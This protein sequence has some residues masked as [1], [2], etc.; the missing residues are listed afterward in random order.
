MQVVNMLY[1]PQNPERWGKAHS[2]S[3]A[4]GH[5]TIVRFKIYLFRYSFSGEQKL[6]L[7]AP[8]YTKSHK[9]G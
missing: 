9:Y 7:S 8:N 3:K 4:D 5:T 6:T 1:R 2:I